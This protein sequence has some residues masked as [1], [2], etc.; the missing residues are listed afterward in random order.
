MRFR[1]RRLGVFSLG[2]VYASNLLAQATATIHG[3]VYDASGAVVPASTVTATNVNTSLARVVETD[4]SGQYNLPLLPVGDYQVRVEK[5]GFSAFVQS[6]IRLQVNTD[7]EVNAK[8]ELRST[9][10]QVTV[11]ADAT[12]VQTT[13]TTLSQVIDEKRITE[14]PLR[15][16]TELAVSGTSAGIDAVR[17]RFR[18][19]DPTTD[20][21]DVGRPPA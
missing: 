20:R 21:G 8:L 3:T 5:D 18:E 15:T 13:T 7:V 6:G 16:G 4:S 1:S 10:D 17:T 19:G 2:V 9:A 11:L 14:L 12:L